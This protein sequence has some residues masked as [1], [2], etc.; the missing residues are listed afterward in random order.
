MKFLIF[1]ITKIFKKQRFVFFALYVAINPKMIIN[2][3]TKYKNIVQT[4]NVC[5]VTIAVV[6]CLRDSRIFYS[7]AFLATG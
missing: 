1:R 6:V 3:S 2:S 7:V 5:E 4:E